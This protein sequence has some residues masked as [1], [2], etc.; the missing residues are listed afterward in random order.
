[1]EAYWRSGGIAQRI[2]DLCNRW[3]WVVSVTF[4]PL[5]P[6]VKSLWYPLDRWLG[7]L[8]SRSGRGGEEINSHA[9]AG[10]RTPD[11]SAQCYTTELSRLRI[12]KG[13]Q[14]IIHLV[15][16]RR[17]Q[18]QLSKRRVLPLFRML[19]GGQ[20]PKN[21]SFNYNLSSWE[22]SRGVGVVITTQEPRTQTSR[23]PWKP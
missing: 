5:Y 6:Q 9:S 12:C 23:P 17:E 8:Q 2:R 19:H 15:A 18:T 21:N 10:T 20:S 11:R 16:W 7:G 3:R 22:R 1:M 13:T 14:Q 4:W